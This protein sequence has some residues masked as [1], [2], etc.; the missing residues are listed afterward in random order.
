MK[1]TMQKSAWMDFESTDIYFRDSEGNTF[2]INFA[3]NLDL[4][5]SIRSKEEADSHTFTITKENYQVYSL[6]EQLHDA[7]RDINFKWVL[8]EEDIPCWCDS[9]EERDNYLLE[10]REY[11]ELRMEA[12]RERNVSNYNELYDAENDVITWYSDECSHK[13]AN[14]VR[15]Y[16]E[17]DTFKVEFHIQPYVQGY[18]YDFHSPC[19]IT[20]RFRNSG[21]SY[22]PFNCLFMKMYNEMKKVDDVTDEGH[23]MHVEEYL[24]NE[25]VKKLGDRYGK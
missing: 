24:Y 14:Y 10:R 11:N 8:S 7:I 23:Q 12:Y 21:S 2:A 19:Y 25:K 15:L 9:Y 3:G 22:D 4:Y 18:D 5:W 13:V 17:D 1:V 6:F 16:K 20:V